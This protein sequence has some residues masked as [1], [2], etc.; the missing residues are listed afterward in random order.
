MYFRTFLLSIT[1]SKRKDNMKKMPNLKGK[2][3][4][5]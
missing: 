5:D 1:N 2:K 4:K 3:P